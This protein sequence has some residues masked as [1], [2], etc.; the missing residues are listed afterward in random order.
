MPGHA[1]SGTSSADVEIP[2]PGSG[3][4]FEGGAG[5][6]EARTLRR[7]GGDVGHGVEGGVRYWSG[8]RVIPSPAGFL[9]RV[10][11]QEQADGVVGGVEN[12]KVHE[13]GDGTGLA[14]LKKLMEI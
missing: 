9:L 4:T 10:A 13:E 8:W 11:G 12:G 3:A 2:Q 5:A 14:Q 6:A 7:A 1:E